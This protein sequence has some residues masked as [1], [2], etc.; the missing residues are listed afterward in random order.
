M[1]L[2]GMSDRE[3]SPSKIELSKSGIESSDSQMYLFNFKIMKL[4][5]TP[6]SSVKVSISLQTGSK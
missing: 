6:K 1:S 5:F 4:E 3:I 2:D